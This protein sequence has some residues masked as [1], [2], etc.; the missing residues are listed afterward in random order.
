MFI[1]CGRG[2]LKNTRACNSG[3]KLANYLNALCESSAHHHNHVGEVLPVALNTLK[4]SLK[5]VDEIV[6]ENIQVKEV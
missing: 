2:Y 5:N 6:A 1:F 4:D 3:N